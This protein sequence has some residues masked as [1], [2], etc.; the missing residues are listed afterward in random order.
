MVPE[1]GDDDRRVGNHVGKGD[2]PVDGSQCAALDLDE[3]VI[4]E[5]L[6]ICDDLGRGL[7]GRPPHALPI[8]AL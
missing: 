8:E 2:R 7:H 6:G 4:G 3:A 1:L 5:K